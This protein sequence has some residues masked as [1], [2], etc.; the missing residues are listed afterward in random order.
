M[1]KERLN[2]S[3]SKLDLES[4]IVSNN[5]MLNQVQHDGFFKGEG[6]GLRPSRA[7]LRSGFTLIELLV[8]VLIIG[9]LAAVAVPQ[10]QKAVEKSK[11]AQA[12][13]LLT[14]LGNALNVYYIENGQMPTSF[15]ELDVQIPD[16]NGNQTWY[17]GADLKD[18][19]SNNDW[20]LQLTKTAL[21]IGRV[22]GSYK[23]AG[24]T[25]FIS[26]E[27]VPTQQNICAERT[28][29]GITFDKSPGDYCTKIMNFPYQHT[30]G[31]IRWFD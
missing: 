21:Y 3:H 17:E 25:Y 28:A 2:K 5:E 15:S 22:S 29:S 9:I 31:G 4:L 12:L 20:S 30:H 8:V 1:K 19:K 7:P 27:N 18:T 6:P 11:A 10:Y 26:S 23:G 14:S 13:T 16:W 24:F